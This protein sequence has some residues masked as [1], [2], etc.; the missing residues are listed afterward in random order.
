MFMFE[1]F[2]AHPYKKDNVNRQFVQALFNFLKIN[3]FLI[4]EY[5]NYS[6]SVIKMMYHFFPLSN[7]A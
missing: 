3:P 1:P 4:K 7:K 5:F 2:C 6:L